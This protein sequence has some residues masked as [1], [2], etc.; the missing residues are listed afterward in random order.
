MKRLVVLALFALPLT[1]VHAQD[2]GSVAGVVR[3]KATGMP[4]D[5]AD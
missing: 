4:L 2:V 1:A 3:D 5:G